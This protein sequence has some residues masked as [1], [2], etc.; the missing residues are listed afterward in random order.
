MISQF[1]ALDNRRVL[2]RYQHPK[3]TSQGDRQEIIEAYTA[4]DEAQEAGQ[5]AVRSILVL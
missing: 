2:I 5:E 1:R 3:L 4:F